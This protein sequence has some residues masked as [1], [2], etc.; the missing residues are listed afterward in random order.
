MLAQGTY[1]LSG[2][3]CNRVYHIYT[4]QTAK[5]N[6]I[7]QAPRRGAAKLADVAKSSRTS[8]EEEVIRW[9]SVGNIRGFDTATTLLE[10]WRT[11]Q[12]NASNIGD[13]KRERPN[14]HA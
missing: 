10:K 5:P 11:L 6:P 14:D 7:H 12:H 4:A 1:M 8:R 3:H 9:I 2:I 13:T